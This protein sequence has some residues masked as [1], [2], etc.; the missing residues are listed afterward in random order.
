MKIYD[1]VVLFLLIIKIIFI[2]LSITYIYLHEIK[3][4]ETSILAI[5]IKYWKE[6]IEFIFI[7]MMSILMIYL[8]NPRENRTTLINLETKLLFYLFGFIL[9]INAKWE[10]FI[11]K[12]KWFIFLQKI[13]GNNN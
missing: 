7:F 6:K 4:D 9:I 13:I 11:K 2:I 5:K 8:F 1:N 12:S 10:Q 3:G